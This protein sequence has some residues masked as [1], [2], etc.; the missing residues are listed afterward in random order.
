M[1][2]VK[3]KSQKSIKTSGKKSSKSIKGLTANNSNRRKKIL[4][5]LAEED[6]YQ[7]YLK[8]YFGRSYPDR[9]LN[10]RSKTYLNYTWG[11]GAEHEMQL[12]HI[13][14]DADKKG[15]ANSTILFNLLKPIT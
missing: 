6:R 11:I 15:I 2:S 14:R 1:P 9:E 7:E 4:K 8:R 3:N 13:A 10:T 5:Y 12:F